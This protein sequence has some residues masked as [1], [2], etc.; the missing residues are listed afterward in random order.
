MKPTGSAAAKKSRSKA[1]RRLAGAAQND[2]ERR[3][4]AGNDAP[5]IAPLQLA[6]DPVGIG[7]RGRLRCGRNTPFRRDRRER[8]SPRGSPS[9]SGLARLMRSH[10]CR[11]ASSLRTEA[12]LDPG[13]ARFCAAAGFAGGGRGR[14][15]LERR[16]AG[17]L[18]RLG[19]WRGP[20][21]SRPDRRP[22]PAGDS[23]AGAARRRRGGPRHRLFRRRQQMLHCR[24]LLG[25]DQLVAVRNLHAAGL[26]RLHLCRTLVGAD[27][28]DIRSAADDAAVPQPLLIGEPQ[29]AGEHPRSR[30]ARPDV[31]TSPRK[32]GRASRI[33]RVGVELGSPVRI[34]RSELVRHRSHLLRR[35]DPEH[36]EPRGDDDRDAADQ[37][38]ARARQ[39]RDRR[40]G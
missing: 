6:A 1:V 40:R 24:A 11:A 10:S 34:R 12:E 22:P 16:F 4:S 3:V 31:A 21:A 23:A 37:S 35:L 9:R 2:R 18:L 38:Q 33:A 15:G 14:T 8:A 28:R 36:G 19:L 29:T 5:D 30:R 32:R 20:R 7:D 26:L 27:Q 25:V 39:F 13:A 17:G